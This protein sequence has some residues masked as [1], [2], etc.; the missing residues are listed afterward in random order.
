MKLLLKRGSNNAILNYVGDRGELFVDID[1]N[2]LR[3]SDGINKAG[4][5]IAFKDD[6]TLYL[7]TSYNNGNDEL[8]KGWC[9]I[10]Q[11]D[12]ISFNLRVITNSST[13]DDANRYSDR[14]YWYA[15]GY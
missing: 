11:K 15:C 5:L 7:V 10:R 6:I 8:A 2:Q 13:V 4:K 1:N 14:C 12:N 9:Q 3:L